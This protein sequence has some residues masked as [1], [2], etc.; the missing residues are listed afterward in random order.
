[1]CGDWRD[2][3]T[4]GS[5]TSD[6]WIQIYGHQ[7]SRPSLFLLMRKNRAFIIVTRFYLKKKLHLGNERIQQTSLYGVKIPYLLA[8]W[9]GQG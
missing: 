5:W 4:Y 7:A 2:A 9:A 8:M 6:G 3:L 1:M